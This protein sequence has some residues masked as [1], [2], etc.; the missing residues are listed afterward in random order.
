MIT[1]TDRWLCISIN[2]IELFI[3]LIIS[4]CHTQSEMIFRGKIIA[5][6][7][8][9]QILLVISLKCQINFSA[10]QSVAAVTR[11]PD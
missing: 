3:F 1:Y 4:A 6:F 11:R 5:I 7:I 9:N 2:L 8:Q 10:Y